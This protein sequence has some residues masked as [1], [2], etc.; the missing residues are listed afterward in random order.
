MFFKNLCLKMCSVR[1]SVR[2]LPF[3]GRKEGFDSPTEYHIETYF[4]PELTG[5]NNQGDPLDLF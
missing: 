2:T 4:Q 5:K 1:L 3:H